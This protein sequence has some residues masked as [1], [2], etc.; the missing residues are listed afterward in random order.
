MGCA[1]LPTPALSTGLALIARS[2][3]YT[4][5]LRTS[6]TPKSAS[7]TKSAERIRFRTALACV[8]TGPDSSRQS[9]GFN[10]EADSR[11]NIPVQPE[12]NSQDGHVWVDEIG[13]SQA[14][15]IRRMRDQLL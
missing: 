8:N 1:S 2:G 9:T 13:L 15:L 5:G 11:P 6:N 10:R 14:V 4:T 12:A 7:D 3:L